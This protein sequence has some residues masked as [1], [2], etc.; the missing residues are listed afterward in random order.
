MAQN[1]NFNPAKIEVVKFDGIINLDLWRCEVFDALTTLN[2][3]D[4]VDLQTKPISIDEVWTRK[5]K[6][7]CA[8]IRSCLT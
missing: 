4:T 8:V 2:L 3:D 5:N 6:M 1:L 7:T